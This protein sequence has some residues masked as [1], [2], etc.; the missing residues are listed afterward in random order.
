M[1]TFCVFNYVVL[2]HHTW[3]CNIV[4]FTSLR[5]QM[6]FMYACLC[7]I[8]NFKSCCH[9]SWLNRFDTG[10]QQSR[11]GQTDQMS[12]TGIRFVID[13]L[14]KSQS[15]SNPELYQPEPV[16][17]ITASTWIVCHIDTKIKLIHW[18]TYHHLW[19]SYSRLFL[20]FCLCFNYF[21]KE[22]TCMKI[23]SN[24]VIRLIILLCFCWFNINKL[25]SLPGSKKGNKPK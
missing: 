20:F 7:T 19:Y 23:Y 25:Y 15:R 3:L 22:M 11:T 14:K 8:C 24:R 4:A 1:F 18:G 2:A 5:R 16:C 13:P 10:L 12:L 6:L 17:G 21:S 9:I